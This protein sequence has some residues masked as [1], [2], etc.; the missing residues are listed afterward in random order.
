MWPKN[1]IYALLL[2]GLC[3]CR[4]T[5]CFAADEVVQLKV[6]DSAIH[7][8][9][10][11]KMCLVNAGQEIAII[12]ERSGSLSLLELRSEI[13]REYSGI[14]SPTDLGWLP[15][16]QQLVIA[17]SGTGSLCFLTLEPQPVAIQRFRIGRSV[18][19][20]AVSPDQKFVAAS[21]TWDRS[22]TLVA[23]DATVARVWQTVL[24]FEPRLVRFHPSGKFL[25]ALDAFAG[26][27]AV[28]DVA[29]GTIIGHQDI[30]GHQFGGCEF[31][32]E[33]QCLLTHQ[34]LHQEAT[35]ANNIASGLVIENVIQEVACRETEPGTMELTPVLVTEI[36]VP[37]HGAADPA[38]IAVRST[39]ERVIAL[40]GVNEIAITNSYNVVLSRLDVGTQPIDLLL[41]QDE[42]LLY[43]LNRLSESISFVDLERQSV[44]KTLPLGGQPQRTNRERGEE[45]FLDG[46]RSRFGWYSCQSCHVQNHTNSQLADTFGDETSGA[47]KRVLS[48]LGGRDNNPW[49]WN[50]SMRSLH[51][52]V[53][54][55]GISTMRGPGF[56][57]RE[58][59][60]IVAFLHSLQA[61]PPFQPATS[62]ADEELIHA[63]EILFRDLGCV[64][65][66]IP[67]L[68]YTSDL[69]YDVGLED[70]HGVR[71]FNPPSLKG[72]GYQRAFLH[73][74][75][76]QKLR[77]V[78]VE[79]GHQLHDALTEG[80][81]AA[82]LRFLESL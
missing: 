50:G 9:R 52:Q 59:N 54:K 5:D 42:R 14:H 60:D 17:E 76:A 61:P 64:H 32:S 66:H 65:C 55:S 41:S 68:T 19:D 34:I 21:T 73:D 63:G 29:S 12:N 75:R 28:L 80:E 23:L 47:A 30:Q 70:E 2:P 10:P 77:D 13:F 40:S 24:S 58:S 22:I 3:L 4:I 38:D 62:Q 79:H 71:K 25:L 37:S 45:L 16:R 18:N 81:L 26:N 57:A 46:H 82:L 56:T 48:L 8:R 72:V 49:A 74:G 53:L 33:N 43:C 35:T 36:G 11:I 15:D 44:L 69:L 27:I 6:L 7:F 20:L 67:P 31:L 1:L 51:D 78:F 39:G